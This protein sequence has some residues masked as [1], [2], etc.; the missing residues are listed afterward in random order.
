MC[1]DAPRQPVGARRGVRRSARARRQTAVGIA[2]RVRTGA[3]P[4]RTRKVGRLVTTLLAGALFLGALTG[5]GLQKAS[6]WVSE[7]LVEQMA[8]ADPAPTEQP[9]SRAKKQP[10]REQR[11]GGSGGAQRTRSSGT[12]D[13]TAGSVGV[14][15]SLPTAR[16]ISR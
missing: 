10:K 5:G 12:I 11:Q 14:N 2:D 8:P 9:A 15:S 4:R 3:R 16:A 13:T 7:Q 1:S 6:D